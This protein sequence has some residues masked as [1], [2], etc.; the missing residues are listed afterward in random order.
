MANT[1]TP[2][3]LVPIRHKSGAPYNGAVN[4]YYVPS[5]YATALFVGDPVVKTGTA[6]T[7]GVKRIGGNF[8]IGAL[9]EV[10][11][12]TAG[13]TNRI[14]GVVVG[15]MP[16]NN[17]SLTYG[18][19]STERIAL[20]ADDPDLVFEAQ[21][22]DALAVTGIGANANLVFTHSGHDHGQVRGRG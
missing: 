18:A 1:D 22:D 17:E 20:V 19:A 4:P 8:A 15:F 14:S 7:A 13:A 21:G 11:K 12:A 9:P 2:M 6:N 5:T 16:E 10:N 3:G